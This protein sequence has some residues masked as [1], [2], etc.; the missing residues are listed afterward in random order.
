MNTFISMILKTL[1]TI[2]IGV[3][4]FQWGIHI[5]NNVL[6]AAVTQVGVNTFPP[7]YEPQATCEFI[8]KICYNKCGLDR[9][10]ALR[11]CSVKVLSCDYS[12]NG[13]IRI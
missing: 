10:C 3:L 4:V 9:N 5:V 13:L 8:N 1:L 12:G 2:F 6:T 7:V 11:K